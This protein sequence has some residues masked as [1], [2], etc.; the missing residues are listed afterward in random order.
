[1]PDKETK[2]QAT[3]T[4]CTYCGSKNIELQQTEAFI[5]VGDLEEEEGRYENE[6]DAR[7]YICKDCHEETFAWK[8]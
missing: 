8:E 3:P 5:E 6:G 2:L 4:F 1:M 7:R